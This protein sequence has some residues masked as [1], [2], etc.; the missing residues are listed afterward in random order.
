MIKRVFLVVD[1]L[2]PSVNREGRSEDPPERLKIKE[3]NAIRFPWNND[4]EGE[5]AQDMEN[6]RG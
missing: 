1:L 3:K 5:F 6:V 4:D 2:S